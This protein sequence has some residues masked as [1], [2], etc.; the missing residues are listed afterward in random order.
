MQIKIVKAKCRLSGKTVG[1]QCEEMSGK[2]VA[3]GIYRMTDAEAG[4]RRSEIDGRN[5]S[6]DK[7]C[8]V[9]GKTGIGSCDCYQRANDC[10]RKP[11]GKDC[12]HCRYLEQIYNDEIAD[13]PYTQWKGVSRIEG[14]GLDA[15]GNAAGSQFDLAKDGAF[16]G[17]TIFVFNFILNNEPYDDFSQ[18]Y[19]ALRKKGFNVVEY[20]TVPDYRAFD[21]LLKTPRS[22]A[23]IISSR[24][25]YLPAEYARRLVEYFRA[26]NGLYLWGDNVPNYV[27]ANIML[28]SI[29]G[30]SVYMRGDY[31]GEKILTLQTA[32]GKPG[33]IANHLLS[34]GIV[35]F[36]EGV[37]IANIVQNGC[38]K[39]LMYASDGQ[40]L[41]AYD[42]SERRRLICDGGF[43]R[44]FC[45]WDKAGTDRYVV[46][47]AAWL[48][49]IERF[50]YQPDR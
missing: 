4:S 15:H 45:S 33:I 3:R 49:N 40:L 23:W 25:D 39:P 44:L 17:Y 20:K 2:Y 10:T 35:N 48:T 29:Y 41:A 13:S 18:A 38:L 12:L 32:T 16:K 27:E 11:M 43:T 46:N 14:V 5:I 6:V 22:Q 19:E 34:T 30:E 1:I 50:G 42:D 26:G 24:S 8:P 31:S 36:Y 21:E 9:C 28:K 37:T 47:A 7:P